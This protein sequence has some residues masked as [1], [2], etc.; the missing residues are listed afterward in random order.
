[1]KLDKKVIQKRENEL[2]KASKYLKSEFVGID[3]II[4]KFI[5][6][7]KI[8]YILPE[9]QSRPLIVNLWGITGVGKTDLVRKFIKAIEFNDRFTEIQMDSK[10]GTGTIEDYLEST[11]ESNETQGVLLLDEIQRFRTIKDTGEENNTNKYQD[12]WMLLSDGIFQSNAKIKQQLMQMLLEEKYWSERE[13]EE[14]ELE[15]S[16]EEKKSKKKKYNTSWWEA[17]R[18]KRLLKLTDTTS[19]IMKWDEQSK[20]EMIKN[21]LNSG[22]TYEGKKYSKLLIIISGNLDEAFTM[23]EQVNDADRDADVYHDYSKSI[24]IITIKGAL[25]SRFKPEQIARLGNIHLIYPIPSRKVYESIIKQKV[26]LILDNIKETNDIDITVDNTVLN[27]IY[28]NGVFPTQGVRPVISTVS[29][30]LENSLPKFIYEYLKANAGGKIELTYKDGHLISTIGGKTVK[31]EVPTVLD[32]IKSIQ[33]DNEKALVSVHEA[34]HAVAYALLYKVVPTQIVASTT[35]EYADGFVGVHGILGGKMQ[36][37]S[38]VRIAL[39]GRVAEELVFG[40]D[41]ISSGASGDFRHAT[42]VIA[43]YVRE[44]GFDSNLGT[45]QTL[46]KN[47]GTQKT[48]LQDTDERIEVMLKEEYQKTKS[49]IEQNLDFLIEISE[50]LM[51]KTTLTTQEFQKIA[52]NHMGEKIAIISASNQL[53]VD[54][55]G[56]LKNYIKNKGK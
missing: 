42:S 51:D 15:N 17:S 1:M 52:E 19:E 20:M 36:F 33:S 35:N 12:L 23:A 8:W 50:K 2:K 45:F 10:D 5:N 49:L 41:Y 7:I 3:D 55:D 46:P 16:K 6:S 31:C 21:R 38:D 29:S 22:E 26:D 27:T 4:D 39:A 18:L 28:K 9:I 34:G 47:D 37:I 30:M 56:L 43:E 32:D 40:D 44:Y 14:E 11:F 25:R 54:Y 48:N 24:D 13:D 53:E